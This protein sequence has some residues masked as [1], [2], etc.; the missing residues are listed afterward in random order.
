MNGIELRVLQAVDWPLLRAMRIRA[1]TL[2]P[3]L[4]YDTGQTAADRP[5]AHWQNL[6][7]GS[8]NRFFALYDKENCIGITG[9]IAAEDGKSGM[10]GYSFIEPV[11]RGKGLVDLIYRARLDHA[12]GHTAWT[13]LVTD[14]RAGNEPSRK[15]ILKYGFVPTEKVMIDWPDGSRDYEYRYSLDLDKLRSKQP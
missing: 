2:H 11:Y 9:V 13:H 5:L 3:D 6:L 14:H 12:L 8:D 1:A 15:S 4:F 7:S 10:I